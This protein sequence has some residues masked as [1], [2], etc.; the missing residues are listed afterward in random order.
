M[1]QELKKSKS[2]D[3][4]TQ[5]LVPSTEIRSVWLRFLET[6]ATHLGC[7]DNSQERRLT[8]KVALVA[9]ALHLAPQKRMKKG[10]PQ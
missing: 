5:H 6:Q 1:E 9:G 10:F 3:F 8:P 4:K 2:I 7:V